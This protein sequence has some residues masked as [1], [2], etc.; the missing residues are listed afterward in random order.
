[1]IQAAMGFFDGGGLRGGKRRSLHRRCP[2]AGRTPKIRDYSMFGEEKYWK[3][4]L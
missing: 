2:Y 3:T 1:L 4:S